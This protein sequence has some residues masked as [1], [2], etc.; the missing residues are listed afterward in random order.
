MKKVV[1]ITCYLSGCRRE[2]IT[3]ASIEWLMNEFN[4]INEGYKSFVMLSDL[5]LND[6]TNNVIGGVVITPQNCESVELEVIEL[7]DANV[8]DKEGKKDEHD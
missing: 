6:G 7:Y 3:E 5:R 8:I 4:E 1:L 2:Y